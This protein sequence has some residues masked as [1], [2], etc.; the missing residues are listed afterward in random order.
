MDDSPRV[1]VAVGPR[2]Y[3]DGLAEGI[4][5]RGSI[6]VVAAVAS[7]REATEILQRQAAD[8]V[9]LDVGLEG[10]ADFLPQT[11]ACGAQARVLA[12]AINDTEADVLAWAG[13]GVAGFV[14]TS[15]SLDSLAEC[16]VAAQRGEFTCSP[17]HASML[18]RHVAA[19]SRGEAEAGASVALT[20]R[21]AQV[22]ALMRAGLSNKLIARRLGIQLPTVK[23][24]VHQVLHRLHVQSRQEVGSPSHRP[25]DR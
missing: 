15:D 24:H 20:P 11:V 9:L 19:L 22:L 5:R 8:V 14:T 7:T 12:L 2:I 3:R 13:R 16:I 17:R 6:T 25:A 23:N 21:Q 10:A 18:L 1:I 4:Q